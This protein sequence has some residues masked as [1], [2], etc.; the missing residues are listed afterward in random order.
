MTLSPDSISCRPRSSEYSAGACTGDLETWQ[1][2]CSTGWSATG[3]CYTSITSSQLSHGLLDLPAEDLWTRHSVSAT[4]LLATSTMAH[5]IH[6]VLHRAFHL[7]WDASSVSDE[8]CWTHKYRSN[9]FWPSS[10]SGLR[11]TSSTNFTLPLLCT[12]FGERPRMETHCLK[13]YWHTGIQKTAE[14]HFRLCCNVLFTD[15]WPLVLCFLWATAKHLC[16]HCNRRAI[17]L[18][19]M[20]LTKFN[21]LL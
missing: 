20:V 9:A 18:Q 15:F 8:H 3:D 2:Q 11:V 6:T 14:T 17:N 16:A 5:P 13:I 10:S 1:L 7:R 21:N 4:V 12:K 19:V